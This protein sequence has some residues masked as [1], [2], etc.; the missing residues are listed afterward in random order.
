MNTRLTAYIVCLVGL[1]VVTPAEASKQSDSQLS[2]KSVHDAG[3][4]AFNFGPAILTSWKS[5]VFM[6]FRDGGAI[7]PI[8][9][10]KSLAT[11]TEPITFDRYEISDH[12]KNSDLV[13]QWLSDHLCH[14]M[15]STP[16]SP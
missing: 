5:A 10:P 12:D 1:A 13:K 3:N 8:A 11:H 6:E 2:T 7:E 16:N 14:R 9:F 4:F 15:N